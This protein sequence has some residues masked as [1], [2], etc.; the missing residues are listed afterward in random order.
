[1]CLKTLTVQQFVYSL[2]IHADEKA[3]NAGG[4]GPE[5]R[6]SLEVSTE[7]WKA[8]SDRQEAAHINQTYQHRR[9]LE[10]CPRLVLVHKKIVTIENIAISPYRHS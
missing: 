10:R 4:R 7:Q 9:S 2:K 6:C 1:M 3:E 8:E 5:D